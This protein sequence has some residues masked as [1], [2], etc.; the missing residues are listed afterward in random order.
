MLW[1]Q[2]IRR[3][4]N[5]DYYTCY[6][7]PK[8]PGLYKKK[9]CIRWYSPKWKCKLKNYQQS[10]APR[11]ISSHE[12]R[13]YGNF[14]SSELASSAISANIELKSLNSKLDFTSRYLPE[15]VER[16]RHLIER[17]GVT[18]YASE[19]YLVFRPLDPNTCPRGNYQYQPIRTIGPREDYYCVLARRNLCQRSFEIGNYN[20]SFLRYLISYQELCDYV[21][22]VKQKVDSVGPYSSPY[23]YIF[24]SISI[25]L[26]LSILGSIYLYSYLFL[27][28]FFYAIIAIGFFE[29][30]YK[31]A[32]MSTLSYRL[33]LVIRNTK[34]VLAEKGIKATA[35]TNFIKFVPLLNLT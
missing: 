24:L 13:Q 30:Y 32:K 35:G 15:V 3:N 7:V 20:S 26:I 31:K 8:L 1:Y 4:W 17:K 5:G 28:W 14:V 11:L 29:Y 25:M 9:A 23:I 2:P 22:S 18:V 19:V 16:T 27:F 12:L 33:K 34:H 6:G 10:F 21:D